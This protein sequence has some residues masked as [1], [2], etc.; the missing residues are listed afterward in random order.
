M[1]RRQ[2]AD[3]N[4]KALAGVFR[5]DTGD[6]F[7]PITDEEIAAKAEA[8]FPQAKR[9]EMAAKLKAEVEALFRKGA[10]E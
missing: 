2:F 1:K 9:E 5:T 7:K 8:I 6:A 10:A 3:R 4:L